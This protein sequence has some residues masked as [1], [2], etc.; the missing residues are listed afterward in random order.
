MT[1]IITESPQFF[2][3]TILEWKKLL[4]PEKYKDTIISSLQFLVENNRVKVNAFVIMDN[5]IHL[6]WQMMAG[7]KSEAAQRDFM[8]YTAQKIKQDLIKSHPAVLA[9][10][11]V[12][13][14]DR[15]Y[16]FW[17]RNAL[18][19]ELG[20][21]EMLKQKL[22]YIHY[23]AVLAGLCNLP[24]EYKYSTARFYETGVNDWDFVT[25]YTE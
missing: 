12:N 2:T 4:K 9:H 15:E 11:K 10:F 6:I 8:K 22:E 20:T 23:N 13:A 25:H 7:I 17:E 21:L 19:I 24:E 16:Q 14:K 3:A 18:S 5:H 1:A